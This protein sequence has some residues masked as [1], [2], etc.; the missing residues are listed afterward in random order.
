MI[1][2]IIPTLNEEGNIGRCIESLQSEDGHVEVIVAD[3]GSTDSTV[4]TARRYGSLVVTAERCRGCQMNAGASV[5]GGDMLLFLHADATLERGWS[6]AMRD[7]LHSGLF[8]GGAFRFIINAPGL[9]YRFVEA[10][11]ALRCSIFSLPYGDQGIFM[12]RQTFRR[13]GGF[14][15]IPLM[16]DVDMIERMKGLGRI[17]ILPKRAKTDARR[18]RTK[19]VVRTSI[20]NRT[21][22]F[23]YRM[24]VDPHK[25]A[26]IYYGKT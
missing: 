10:G 1:S 12:A 15:E 13:L 4:E 7:A 25:L 14:R 24:G 16:E 11:V 22:M 3:G 26:R 23:L 8:V 9:R 21:M 20:A 5:A 17:G 6:G 18:W 19:G 2:V